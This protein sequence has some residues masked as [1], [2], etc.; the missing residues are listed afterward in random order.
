MAKTR[1]QYICQKCG[2]VSPKYMGRCPN[3]G[4]FGTFAE[5]E[6]QKPSSHKKKVSRSVPEKLH[7]IEPLSEKRISTEIAELDRVL[8]G[9]IVDGSLI[10]IGGSPGIG[11]STLAL[12][13]CGHLSSRDV[14]VLYISGEESNKQL[15]LRSERLE[16]PS[17]DIYVQ[18]ETNLE[19]I[20]SSIQELSPKVVVID[21]IQSVYTERLESAPGGVSQV[22]EC[23]SQ[24]ML[25]A[26][27]NGISIF[28]IGHVTKAGAIAG[29]RLLEHIVDTVLYFEGERH[30]TYRILR[31]VK[32]R[33]GSTNEIGVFEMRESGLTEVNNPSEI[34]L[35]ER[36]LNTPGSIVVC[37]MEGTRPLLLELQA[38]VSTSGYGTAQR[39]TNGIDRTR[40]AMLLAVL[41][42]RVGL[43][44]AN[45]DVFVNV[46]GGVKVDEPSVDL[47][48]ICAVTS[49]FRNR[50]I[51]SKTVV[52]GEV[53]L[54][55]EVRTV[56]QIEKRLTES[57]K[58]G[59][60][61]CV[62]PKN[63]EKGLGKRN[64]QIEIIGV[65]FVWEALD[66]LLE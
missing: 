55:G 17:S 66:L 7:A 48:T 8:G 36:A 58:L 26:K 3:C 9:G 6:V 1:T 51:D 33:F 25:I 37:S 27:Q 28:I 46:A 14:D 63:N 16:L 19:A 57:E 38:L 45:E 24:L 54:G 56:T 11:K 30:H 15:K 65:N 4:E 61:R 34:F 22:R 20:E 41:E 31:A 60:T 29:P 42:K 32:N 12:Q 18:A 62:I 47:G 10:L 53:G 49:G 52:I 44:L 64:F 43:N 35:S 40:L 2:T 5:E 50:P 21:S 59:F 39:V 23:T 13:V